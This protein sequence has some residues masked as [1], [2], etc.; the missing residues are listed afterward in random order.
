MWKEQLLTNRSTINMDII[1]VPEEN[2]CVKKLKEY[3]EKLKNMPKVFTDEVKELKN[4]PPYMTS[5]TI[6]ENVACKALEM[7]NKTTWEENEIGHFLYNEGSIRIG[8]NPEH[9]DG[10]RIEVVLW[11]NKWVIE[12]YLIIYKTYQSI[13]GGQLMYQDEP[14]LHLRRRFRNNPYP[15][16]GTAWNKE[17]IEEL[18]KEIDWR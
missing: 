6:P 17:R 14:I 13:P 15:N 2:S 12:I 18:K 8:G 5:W 10:H 1:D 3:S 9:I 7:L 16:R 4:Y 11:Y